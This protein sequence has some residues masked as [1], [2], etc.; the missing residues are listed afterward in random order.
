MTQSVNSVLEAIKSMTPEEQQ[1]V[2]AELEG[3]RVDAAQ[4]KVEHALAMAGLID[5]GAGR[6]W[7]RED[8]ASFRAW[9]P[10][11]V[12]GKPVSETLIEERR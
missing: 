7:T 2:L 10:S 9:R 5:G 4:H 1:E 11:P 6:E 3:L 8:V 12:S